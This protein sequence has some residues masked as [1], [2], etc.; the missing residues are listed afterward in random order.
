MTDTLYNWTYD[1]RLV[2]ARKLTHDTE[3]WRHPDKLQAS[4]RDMNDM[5]RDDLTSAER[6]EVEMLI[7]Q[8]HEREKKPKGEY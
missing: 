8:L 1:S 3:A 6:A 2:K 4:L 5:L 7:R